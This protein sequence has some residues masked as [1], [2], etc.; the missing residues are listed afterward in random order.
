MYGLA[1]LSYLQVGAGGTSIVALS[2]KIT[3]IV[4]VA[5]VARLQTGNVA[6][7]SRCFPWR[8]R[9]PER[10]E[11]RTGSGLLGADDELS[12]VDTESSD[13]S[14]SDDGGA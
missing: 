13:S 4:A 12:D 8:S 9:N 6:L 3:P 1:P 2:N 10:P 14:S 5:S 7:T 11:P